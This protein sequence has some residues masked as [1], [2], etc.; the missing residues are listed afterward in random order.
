MRMLVIGGT[1]ML[2]AC[3][4]GLAAD[5]HRVT[6]LSRSRARFD[7]LPVAPAAPMPMEWL[8]ADYTD[9]P[10]FRLALQRGL[11]TGP[12]DAVLAW[13]PDGTWWDTLFGE[14]HSA[15][16]TGS[17]PWDL[18]RVR[19]SAAAC[20]GFAEAFPPAPANVRLHLIVLG[21]QLAT[22]GSRWLRHDEIAEGALNAV[23]T[24]QRLTVV[25]T[26]DPWERRPSY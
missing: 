11:R 22:Q 23:R 9:S 19:G 20:S 13:M 16:G 25:G 12:F 10:A 7:R 15:R 21:F 2:A 24:A 4:V 6:V 5:G 3:T 8:G 18:Y 26:V 17:S 1:G 14:M